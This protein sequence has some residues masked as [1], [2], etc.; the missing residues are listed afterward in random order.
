MLGYLDRMHDS[1]IAL[2]AANFL[3][4]LAESMTNYKLASQKICVIFQYLVCFIICNKM[5][6]F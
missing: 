6:P 3:P 2:P 1:L 4:T 5:Q